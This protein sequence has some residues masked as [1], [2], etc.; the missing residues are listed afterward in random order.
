MLDCSHALLAVA[1]Q[2]LIPSPKAGHSRAE[3]CLTCLFGRLL[4]LCLTAPFKSF[5]VLFPFQF[6]W[7][8]TN[9]LPMDDY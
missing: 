5:F 3:L 8:S 9:P 4:S 6:S 1:D 7:P 2:D